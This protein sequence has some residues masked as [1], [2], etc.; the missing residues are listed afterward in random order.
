MKDRNLRSIVADVLREQG[1][2]PM[3]I[4]PDE[5]AAVAQLRAARADV[6]VL[7]IWPTP[8]GLLSSGMLDNLDD[9]GRPGRVVVCSTQPEGLDDPAVA[10]FRGGRVERLLIP[11]GYPEL[12]ASIARLMRDTGGRAGKLIRCRLE[13]RAATR[14][15]S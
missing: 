11:F 3:P 10:S 7:E 12:S 8:E 14:S 13:R 9:S 1:H 2:E 15:S 4:A 6:L 5:H